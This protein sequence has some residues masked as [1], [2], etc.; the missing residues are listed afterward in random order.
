MLHFIE[1]PIF[2]RRINDLLTPDEYQKFQAHL[3]TDPT[4]GPT[5]S[6]TGGCRKI[7]WALP[8]KSKS[9]GI[10][11]IYYYLAT[12]GEIHLLYAYPKSEQENLTDAQKAVMKKF[13]E[14]I[15]AAK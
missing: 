14:L 5:I 15:E 13:A 10:R 11:V 12:D 3:L 7:R 4:A 2:E 1:T 6:H 9:G 8:A